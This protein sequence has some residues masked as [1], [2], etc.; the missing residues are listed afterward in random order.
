MPGR[1]PNKRRLGV[2]ER[3]AELLE[4]GLELFATAS[5][6]TLS[7]DAIARAA[8]I[9]KGL[10]YHY[11]PSKR[12]YY[13]A[14]VRLAADRLLNATLEATESDDVPPLDLLQRGLSAY[15]DFVERHG[16]TY[17]ALLR[18]G[19]GT[20]PEILT[21]IEGTRDAF[22]DRL[23]ER[24]GLVDKG[25]GPLLRLA[26]RG[27]VGFVEVTSLSWLSEN[28]IS[29]EVLAELMSETLVATLSAASLKSPQVTELQT[30]EPSTE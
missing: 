19:I 6:E 5:Y 20:D 30:R 3:R 14:T 21:V 2:D 12:D 8:G 23:A 25:Q 1:A 4:L 24:L 16:Q 26:L 18:T 17:A 11:F 10:L 9:S 15:L 13:T 7:I 28:T 22:V 27:W 29:R